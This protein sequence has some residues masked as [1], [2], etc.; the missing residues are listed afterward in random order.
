MIASAIAMTPSSSQTAP[1][2]TPEQEIEAARS[3]AKRNAEQIAKIAL[4]MNVEPAFRF[5]V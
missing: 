3:T 2:S 5:K 1:A 4:P